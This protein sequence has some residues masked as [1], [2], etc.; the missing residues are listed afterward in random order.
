MIKMIVMD[1]D[2][3]LLTDDKNISDYTLS[4]LKKCKSNGIKIVIATARSEKSAK[5][6][7]ELVKL[8]IM[9]L[10]GGALVINNDQKIIYKKLLSVETSDGIINECVK[11]KNVGDLTVET[12]KNYYVSYK[13]SA[14]HPDYMHGEYYNFLN[15]LSQE[16]YKITVEIIDRKIALDIE[17]KFKESKLISFSGENWHRFAHKEAEKIEAINAIVNHE[18]ITISEIVAFGDDYNDIEMVKNCGVGIAME[19]GIEEIKKVAKYICGKNNED[20]IGKWIE[21]NLL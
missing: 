2:G 12:E 11:N 18:N 13:E 21:K 6:C 8:D 10:N 16:T 15:P 3:T 9:I 20:G 5:R 19:N 4:V 17:N 7:I 14:Y 1:L